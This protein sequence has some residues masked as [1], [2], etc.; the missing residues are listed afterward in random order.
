[1][2]EIQ[3]LKPFEK[4]MVLQIPEGETGS[5]VVYIFADSKGESILEKREFSY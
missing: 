3:V 2:E 1:M 4:N 5:V